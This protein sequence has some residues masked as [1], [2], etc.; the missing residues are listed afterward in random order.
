MNDIINRFDSLSIVINKIKI[1]EIDEIALILKKTF[2]EP[3]LED[4]KLLRTKLP[5]EL[6]KKYRSSDIWKKL[7]EICRI[8]ALKKRTA[9]ETHFRKKL[10]EHTKKHIG[11]RSL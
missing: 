7:R 6:R 9:E 3:K 10:S 1:S 8:M 2:L 11:P 4:T 5:K